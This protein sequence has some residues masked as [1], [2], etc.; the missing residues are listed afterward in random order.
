ML[1]KVV[2][3]FYSNVFTAFCGGI[4]IEYFIFRNFQNP[5][6]KQFT[7]NRPLIL[8]LFFVSIL[9]TIDASGHGYFEKTYGGSEAAYNL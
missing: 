5:P 9:F 1:I 7:F 6:M 4:I 8:F 3:N 2:Y